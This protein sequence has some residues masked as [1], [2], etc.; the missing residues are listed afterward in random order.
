VLQ[1]GRDTGA[2]VVDSDHL[3]TFG[4]KTVDQI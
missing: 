1:I 3:V 2:E 4:Q